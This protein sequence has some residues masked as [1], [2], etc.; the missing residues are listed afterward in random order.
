[1][2]TKPGTSSFTS[3]N[4]AELYSTSR[5]R[6]ILHSPLWFE[7]PSFNGSEDKQ[8]FLTFRNADLSGAR[9]TVAEIHNSNLLRPNW[10]KPTWAVAADRRF[11]LQIL[12]LCELNLL[13][14]RLRSAISVGWISRMKPK[15]GVEFMDCDFTHANL[16]GFDFEWADIGLNILLST[17]LSNCRMEKSDFSA[18]NF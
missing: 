14:L 12:F 1:M 3:Q 4:S 15:A 7:N 6:P 8:P 16:S 13:G 2:K 10:L 11:Q 18:S 5:D 17:N 9:F